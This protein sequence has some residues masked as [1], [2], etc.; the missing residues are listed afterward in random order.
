[1]K[2]SEMIEILNINNVPFIPYADG[3]GIKDTLTIYP[4]AKGISY[5]NNATIRFISIDKNNKDFI[6]EIGSKLKSEFYKLEANSR[7]LNKYLAVSQLL[8][9]IDIYNGGKGQVPSGQIK[10]YVDN[11]NAHIY[12]SLDF[13]EI[14]QMSDLIECIR[15][16][17]LYRELLFSVHEVKSRKADRYRGYDKKENHY[18]FGNRKYHED[19]D[20]VRIT[21]YDDCIEFTSKSGDIMPEKQLDMRRKHTL[22][23]KI[24]SALDNWRSH[25]TL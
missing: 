9:A 22:E 18:S 17:E 7:E 21:T 25:Y 4:T 23:G 11:L 3:C 2:I 19:L 5:W 13:S 12:N 20:V 24:L 1:M 15:A 6:Y 14:S 10:Q 8:M 16:D